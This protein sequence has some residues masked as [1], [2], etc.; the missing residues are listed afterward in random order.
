M[1]YCGVNITVISSPHVL[2]FQAILR[3]FAQDDNT[4]FA[5]PL[6]GRGN[7]E[8]WSTLAYASR[9]VHYCGDCFVALAMTYQHLPSLAGK[10][11]AKPTDESSEG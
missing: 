4:V 10:V 7:P 1:V 9:S 6:A 2:P 8:D 5:R 3:R 11:A